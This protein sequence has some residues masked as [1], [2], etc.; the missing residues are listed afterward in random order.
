MMGIGGDL[1]E[2]LLKEA[3]RPAFAR[4][5]VCLAAIVL[6]AATNAE[7]QAPAP[8]DE[9]SVWDL[10][11][12]DHASELPADDFANFACGTNGG[13]PSRP[14]NGWTGYQSCPPDEATGLHEVYFEYDNELELRFKARSLHTQAAV[15]ENTSLYSRPII[16]SA[17]FDDDGFFRMLRVVTDPR[18]DAA[19]RELAVT[20]GGFLR[21]RLDGPWTCEDLPKIEGEQA[22]GGRYEKRRCETIDSEG[23]AVMLETH[24]YRRAG[25]AGRNVFGVPTEGQFW[26][27]TR[28]EV[29]LVGDVPDREARLAV[30]AQAGV[31]GPSER[32]LLIARAANC[33]GCDLRGADLKRADLTGANL[34][35]A[36]LTGANLHEAILRQANLTGAVLDESNLNGADGRLATLAG[37][38]IQRALMYEANFDGADLSQANLTETL[39]GEVS[40]SRA[41]LSGAK[42]WAVDL[43]NARITDADL[44]EADLRFSWA[45]DA[46]FIRSDLSAAILSDTVMWRVNLSQTKLVAAELLSADLLEATLRGADLRDADFSYAR[47]TLAQMAG[48]I[49]DG[50]VW[51]HAA[52]P[53]GF[54]PRE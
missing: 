28:L 35:G 5:A 50:A 26:S 14:L 34:A 54:T 1:F 3:K 39:A 21:A 33:P 36:D 53:G 19:I 51:D 52:L 13:P 6:V 43:R 4:A 16:A 22:F 40:L 2:R 8:I 18:F 42:M 30:I 32:D 47:L 44:R 45:H 29:S 11:I 48:V 24:H 37:A 20:L 25:Q 10:E 15:Y 49:A 41:N 38:S 17:L 31:L 9:P 7:A 23:H 12:G 46:Q 27:E